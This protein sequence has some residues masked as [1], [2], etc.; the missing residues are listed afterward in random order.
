MAR[1]QK[2]AEQGLSHS[3]KKAPGSKKRKKNANG[4]AATPAAEQDATPGESKPAV[5]SKSELHSGASSRSNTST[6]TPGASTG[7]KNSSTAV[8]TARVLEEENERKRRRKMLSANDNLNSLFTKDSKDG[9]SKGSDFMTR[10]YTIPAGEA[11]R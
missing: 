8:L 11:R 6:P 4:D 7:I 1:G 5:P 3:L 2:L 10:G 9:K